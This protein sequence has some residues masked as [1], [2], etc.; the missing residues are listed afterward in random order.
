MDSPLFD[1]HCQMAFAERN[2][3][4]EA[5][6]AQSPAGSWITKR[7]GW[8]P[9]RVSRSCFRVHSAGG[10]G[11]DVVMEKCA[12][13]PHPAAWR[14]QSAEATKKSHATMTWA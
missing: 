3:E 9:G 2:Q 5:R 6:P 11:S 1:N 13:L 4:V 10:M 7:Y 8:S 12:G 14:R